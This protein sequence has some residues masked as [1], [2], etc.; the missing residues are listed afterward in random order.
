M[1][2]V[3]YLMMGLASSRVYRKNTPNTHTALALYA[4]Q[5]ALN[6]AWSPLYFGWG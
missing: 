2:T 4:V 1:W 6:L 5:L 3:L